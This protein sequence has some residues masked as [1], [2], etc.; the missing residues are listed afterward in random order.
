MP[1]GKTTLIERFSKGTG[2]EVLDQHTNQWSNGFTVMAD[3][4]GATIKVETSTGRTTNLRRAVV[5]WC[6]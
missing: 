3:D 1:I 5:R 6:G 4:G 2:V